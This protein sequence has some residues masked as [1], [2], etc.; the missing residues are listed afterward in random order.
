MGGDGRAARRGRARGSPRCAGAEAA[1]VVPG[2]SAGIALAV[3]ACIARGDGRGDGG[4]AAGRRGRADAARARVQVRALRGAGGRAGGVGGRHRR[5]RSRAAAPAAVPASRR[6]S[7][8]RG[9]CRSP[10]SRRSRAPRACRSSSTR[11][12]VSFPLSRAGALGDGAVTSRA[13]RPSTSAGPNG[14]GFV[15]GR[16]GAGRG[17][18]RARLHR[19]RVR[20]VADVRAGV[21]ARS[22][23]G[24]RHRRG[25]G[26]V[27]GARPRRAAGRLRGA[28]R[29]ARGALRGASGRARRAS[30]SSR[31]TSAWS[32]GRSTRSLVRG[33]A[34]TLEPALAAGDPSVRAMVDGDALVFCTEALTRRR[35]RRDRRRPVRASG[36]TERRSERLPLWTRSD[37]GPLTLC[38][39]TVPRDP[40]SIVPMPEIVVPGARRC[41][42]AV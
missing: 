35:G 7:T 21:E 32:T 30:S 25:A 29:G 12:S 10:S 16:G 36:Q 4:A 13:S 9:R 26:G 41:R 33:A 39:L 14:G 24:R 37:A 6:T 42:E 19:L 34:A 3:G 15:A 22:R 38:Y 2:A 20:A 1:R 23:D 40:Q 18:R 31:S 17:H 5:A 11:R 27:G 28:R 8:T